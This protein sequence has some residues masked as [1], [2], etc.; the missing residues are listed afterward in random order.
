MP[1]NTNKNSGYPYLGVW[2][3][4]DLDWGKSTQCAVNSFKSKVGKVKNRKFPLDIK[5]I[6]LN[7]ICNKALECHTSFMPLTNSQIKQLEQAV[8][9]LIQHSIGLRKGSAQDQIWIDRT[10]RNRSKSH[11][12][13][14]QDSVGL[15]R[16]PSPDK[17]IRHNML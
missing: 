6:I 16:S 7:T 17:H 15:H 8:V 12:Q 9:T 13:I 5:I 2:I 1:S 4:A 11:R 10:W 14:I 3:T